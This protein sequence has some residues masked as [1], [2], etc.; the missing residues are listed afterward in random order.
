ME[1]VKGRHSFIEG[2]GNAFIFLNIPIGFS[3]LGRIFACFAGDPGIVEL[4]EGQLVQGF[5][6]TGH[7]CKGRRKKVIKPSLN[8]GND[9]MEGG[10]DIGSTSPQ[11]VPDTQGNI[12]HGQAKVLK[13]EIT[14]MI[15]PQITPKPLFAIPVNLATAAHAA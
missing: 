14:T 9:I 12:R 6:N 15:P 1:G 13:K 2:I 11:S 3:G 4:N 5:T 7:N 10:S 8:I